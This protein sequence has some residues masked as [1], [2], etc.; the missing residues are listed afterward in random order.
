[1]RPGWPRCSRPGYGFPHDAAHDERDVG[2]SLG[3]PPH[4]V[5]VPLSSE[6]DIHPHVP[7]FAAEPLLEIAP[8]PIEHLELEARR[9]NGFPLG[10]VLRLGDD[11]LVVGG[12]AGIV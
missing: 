10:V 1:S 5:G 7:T 6:W 12:N 8:D 11:P 2:G 9:V 4:E 3:E